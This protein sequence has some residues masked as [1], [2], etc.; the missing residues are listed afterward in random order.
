MAA[1]ELQLH[2]DH[3]IGSSN[4]VLGM[5]QIILQGLALISTELTPPWAP[6]PI[7]TQRED[8]MAKRR[9]GKP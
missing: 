2:K 1:G 8:M 6:R 7:I 4:G 5:A 3:G 9:D